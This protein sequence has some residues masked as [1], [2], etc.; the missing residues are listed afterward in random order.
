[1]SFVAAAVTSET[2]AKAT[3][4][5]ETDDL[6]LAHQEWVDELDA[7]GI[8]GKVEDYEDLLRRAPRP[9]SEDAI[10]LLSHIMAC[11]KDENGFFVLGAAEP[12]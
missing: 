12:S 2:A 5:A 6:D 8:H 4:V 3:I 1:M 7:M 11:R 10:A 9:S